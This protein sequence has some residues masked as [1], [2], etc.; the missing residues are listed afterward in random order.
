MET[1][2]TVIDT[3]VIID[4]AADGRPIYEGMTFVKK[5]AFILY[6]RWVLRSLPLLN[7]PMPPGNKAQIFNNS[8]SNYFCMIDPETA[9]TLNGASTGSFESMQRYYDDEGKEFHE[10]LDTMPSKGKILKKV[11]F[12]ALVSGD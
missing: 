11:L 5:F 7:Y 4:K 8:S 6:H 1:F 12:L 3:N 2:I 10:C 9:V